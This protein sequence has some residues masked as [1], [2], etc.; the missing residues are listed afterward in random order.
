MGGKRSRWS[1]LKPHRKFAKGRT[2]VPPQDAAGNAKCEM[3]FTRDDD[4]LNQPWSGVCWM[5]PPYGRAIGEWMR[6]AWQESTRGRTVAVRGE[7]RCLRG[8][9]KFGGHA[10]S[11]PFPSAIVVFR[12]TDAP[13]HA[14]RAESNRLDN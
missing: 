1:R 8:R 2:C 10:N 3:F 7:I 9:L 12:G 6:K 11:A 14:C 4:A 5:N 13:R